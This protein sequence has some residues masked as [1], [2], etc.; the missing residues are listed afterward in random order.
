M[1]D[2]SNDPTNIAAETAAA[3]AP[4]LVSLTDWAATTDQEDAPSS[5]SVLKLSGEPVY[6]SFFTDFPK[7]CRTVVRPGSR[8]RYGPCSWLKCPVTRRVFDFLPT[9]NK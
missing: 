5:L 6:V 4:G 8:V 1:N 7:Y 3:N 2:I 9:Y